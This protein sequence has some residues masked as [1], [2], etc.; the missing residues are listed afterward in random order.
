M[1]RRAAGLL[2]IS[3]VMPAACSSDRTGVEDSWRAERSVEGSVTVVRTISGSV[4][5]GRVEL[6]EELSI[7]QR[8]GDPRYLLGNVQSL[9]SRDDRIYILDGAIPALRIYALDGRHLFDVGRRGDGPGEFREPMSIAVHPVTGRIYV[10]DGSVGRLNVYS[11]DGE[12]LERWPIR[13]SFGTGRQLVMTPEGHLYTPILI[14]YDA[15]PLNWRYGMARCSPAGAVEDTIPVPVYDFE[16]WR[17]TAS[18][19]GRSG[20]ISVPFSPQLVYAFTS[21]RRMVAGIS[22]QYRFEVYDPD[23]SVLR[24][25]KPN[26]R[27]PVQPDEAV[28][29]ERWATASRS[30]VQ[31]GWVWNGP[32]IP[33]YKPAFEAFF[34]DSAGRIWVLRA[35]LGRIQGNGVED[36]TDPSALWNNPRWRDEHFFDVFDSEGAFLGSLP[37]PAG[38]LF[39]P[40]PFIGDDRLLIYS[41][42]ES[43]T[44]SVKRYRL[45]LHREQ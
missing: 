45:V 4:W 30:R 18:H 37:V 19:E 10:R 22:D 24:I 9:W 31:P 32:P 27:I 38:S 14:R 1:Y 35:G 2:V 40:P 34:P 7:G 13:G 26:S 3:A 5:E 42:D 44:P 28:W 12:A 23:D 6:I 39:F 16:P 20:W 15:D 25:E 21:G 29:Y 43:G 11:P 36:S 33:P 41:E 8:E 17:L